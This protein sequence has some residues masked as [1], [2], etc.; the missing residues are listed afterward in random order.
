MF[1]TQYPRVVMPCSHHLGKIGG[2]A[3]ANSVAHLE[4]QRGRLFIP[5]DGQVGGDQN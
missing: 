2:L 5:S 1:I 4:G 3:I